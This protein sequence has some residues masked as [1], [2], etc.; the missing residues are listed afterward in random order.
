MYGIHKA[1]LAEMAKA[2]AALLSNFLREKLAAEGHAERPGFVEALTKHLLGGGTEPFDWD[3]DSG[4][5]VII[6]FTDADAKNLDKLTKEFVSALPDVV[7]QTSSEAAKT[8]LKALKRDW[9]EQAKFERD[10]LQGFRRRLEAR[11]GKGFDGLRMLLTIVREMGGEVHARARRSRSSKNQAIRS[12]LLRLH[13][14]ACQVT[15]E[16]IT[17]MENGYADG[18]MAR[19]RTL[20]EIGVVATVISDGGDEL[21]QRYM[22]HEAVESK[23]ALDEYDRCHQALGFKPMSLKERRRV[24]RAFKSAVDAHGAEFGKPYG[25]A[26]QY[27][28]LKRVTFKELEDAADRSGMRSY[29]KMA[30]YNV[31]A[32]AK[33]VFHRLGVLGD[34]SRVIA[35]ASDAGFAEPGQNT[36]ITL[37]QITA[38]LFRGRMSNL[39]IMIR[40]QLLIS[41]R[42]EVPGALLKASRSLDRDHARLQAEEKHKRARKT[43]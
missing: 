23:L 34:P 43:C 37:V 29:Y 22:A 1:F 24:E 21:A 42:N 3:D 40:M 39:D 18:A 28:G 38:L 10:S 4:D 27:F 15:A 17:L 7:T 33:G 6:A 8:I 9:P 13:T 14:R 31:H 35:G 11:W 32:D 2:P 36:A 30:S 26:A 12:I 25:W 5:D 19:W 20:Y 41:V 16:I